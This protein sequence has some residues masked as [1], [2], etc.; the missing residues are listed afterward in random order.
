MKKAIIT[1]GNGFVGNAVIHELLK[2]NV[3]VWA[4]V[5]PGFST[6]EATSRLHGMDVHI[7]ECDLREIIK[8][9]EILEEREFDVWY[10]FAWDGLSGEKL[11]DY[12]VQLDNVEYVLDS[13]KSA[14]AIGCKKYVGSGSISQYEL[15]EK[16]VMNDGADKHRVYKTAKLACE[17][18]GKSV[19]Y[20]NGIDFIWPI[21]TNI[22]GAGEKSAR[23]INSMIRNLVEG[24]HQSLSEGNQIYDFIYVTDAAKA[25]YC[26]GE[27]GI[28]GHHYVIAQGDAQPLRGFME[29]LRDVVNPEA[30]LGFGEM[31][32]NG[33]YL[34]ADRF[35][36]SE[37]KADTGFEP[38]VSFAE[39]IRKTKEWILSE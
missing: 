33:Y 14:A 5:R 29:T 35:D 10:Q 23:L 20:A 18:M 12:K 13:I 16:A 37:L 9:P 19:A 27:S 4:I 6:Y 25:F 24:K 22:Y 38:E 32:F 1:G 30:E 8:L 17:Y 31:D 15:F 34:G 3:E 7:V 21:I 26:I 28:A 39:G 2:H 36:I 11:T